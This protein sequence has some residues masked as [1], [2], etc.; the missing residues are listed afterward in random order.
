MLDPGEK[1]WAEVPA[2]FNLD[3][4][5]HVNPGEQAQPSVRPW[6]I[7]SGRIVGRLSDQRL[8][9]YRWEK[10]V[11]VRIDL[12]PGHEVVSLDIDDGPA[13]TWSGPAVAPW[14]SR[15]CFFST[16]PRR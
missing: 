10:A 6:L 14:Q 15:R 12:N 5:P 7:T 1:V 8:H 11:G 13:L 9:G 3:W 2:M 16:A 4:R